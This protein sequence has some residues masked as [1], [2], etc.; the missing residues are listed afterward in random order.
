MVSLLRTL[1]GRSKETVVKGTPPGRYWLVELLSGGKGEV[2]RANDT[3]IDLGVAMK[4][5]PVQV[6]LLGDLP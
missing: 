2:Q 5:L 4:P 1:T 3:E 6:Q